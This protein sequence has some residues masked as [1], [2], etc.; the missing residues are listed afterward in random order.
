MKKLLLIATGIIAASVLSLNAQSVAP[1]QAATPDGGGVTH[2]GGPK[3]TALPSDN[4]INN[5]HGGGPKRTVQTPDGT[6]GGTGHG[7]GPKRTALT[8]EQKQLRQE[9][10][11]KYDTN[12]DGRLDKEERARISAEDQARLGQAGQCHHQNQAP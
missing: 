11:E 3:R 12:K 2:G 9:M 6:V 5:G 8:P 7:G 4:D 10:V 1:S